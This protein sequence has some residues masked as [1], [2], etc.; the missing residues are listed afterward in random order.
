MS[1]MDIFIWITAGM[2]LLLI[3]GVA[4]YLRTKSSMPKPLS[5]LLKGICTGVLVLAALVALTV[6][7]GG[8]SL[9]DGLITVGLALG[10][11]GDVVIGISFL[12]GMAA[13]AAGHLCYIG[14]L[15]TISGKPA[16]AVPI[17]AVVY[18]GL[19]VFYK[20]SGVKAGKL[21]TPA[22]VYA[23]VIAAMLSLS[24]TV[25]DSAPILLPAAVLF[26]ASDF[27]LAFLTFSKHN[28][29]MDEVSLWCYYAGQSLFALSVILAR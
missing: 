24:F 16:V 4:V 20:K 13:F 2:Y 15:L 5:L 29:R 8:V 14:A 28:K 7:G 27:M 19:L 9:F 3:P 6:R 10:L 17:W 22:A 1:F 12:G 26:T 18:I 21:E 11:A 23:A 25:T